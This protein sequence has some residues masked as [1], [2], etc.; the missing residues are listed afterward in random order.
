MI[1]LA[2]DWLRIVQTASHPSVRNLPQEVGRPVPVQDGAGL[3]RPV[4][5]LSIG[6]VCPFPSAAEVVTLNP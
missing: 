6:P 1:A 5:F 2:E 3:A 4:R